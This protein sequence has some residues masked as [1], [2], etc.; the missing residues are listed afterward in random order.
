M[1][2]F[3][4]IYETGKSLRWGYSLD[5][6]VDEGYEYTTTKEALI[7][8]AAKSKYRW[9]D[10]AREEEGKWATPIS[11][12]HNLLPM[13]AYLQLAEEATG[14]REFFELFEDGTT[15]GISSIDNDQ[16]TTDNDAPV[17]NLAGQKVGKGYKGIVIINGKKVVK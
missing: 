13:D 3:K 8:P 2:T 15:T 10:P 5:G 6:V 9:L 12:A 1:E 17:Y 11:A 16:L 14:A 4:G 7:N